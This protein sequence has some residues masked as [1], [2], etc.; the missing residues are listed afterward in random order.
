M[1]S[2]KNRA[3]IRYSEQDHKLMIR[4]PR[5]EFEGYEYDDKPLNT[6]EQIN[7]AVADIEEIRK[8]LTELSDR[9]TKL[10]G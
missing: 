3:V 8:S 5:I 2:T 7:D 10:G 9:V 4:A 6:L 1:S